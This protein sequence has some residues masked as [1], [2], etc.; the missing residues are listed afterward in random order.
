[1]RRG[2]G[3]AKSGPRGRRYGSLTEGQASRRIDTLRHVYDEGYIPQK[4]FESMKRD[5]EARAKRT[6]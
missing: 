6:T 1:M 2:V 4:V 3:K 5:L